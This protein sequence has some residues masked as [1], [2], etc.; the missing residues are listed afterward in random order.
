[1][2]F[3]G[4]Q[5]VLAGHAGVKKAAAMR[6]LATSTLAICFSHGKA[7]GRDGTETGRDGVVHMVFAFLLRAQRD[8][9]RE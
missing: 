5:R 6:S 2:L 4:R 8:D 7:W 9:L 3:K 1:M